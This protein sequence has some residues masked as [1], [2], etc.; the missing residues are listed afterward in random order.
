[1]KNQT[2]NKDSFVDKLKAVALI[3]IKQRLLDSA[4]I[5]R[6]SGEKDFLTHIAPSCSEELHTAYDCCQ[7]FCRNYE[8]FYL[9]KTNDSGK[10]KA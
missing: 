6:R 7:E 4:Y 10:E 2:E 3:E 8:H 1:M 5:I 9:A